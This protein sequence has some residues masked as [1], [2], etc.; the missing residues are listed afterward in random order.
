VIRLL[1]DRGAKVN[2]EGGVVDVPLHTAVHGWDSEWVDIVRLLLSQPG[3]NVNLT[4]NVNISWDEYERAGYYGEP[5]D[6]H[7]Q[8]TPLHCA[9]EL[10]AKLGETF[11]AAQIAN[12]LIAKGRRCS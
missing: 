10:A 4:K 3:I 9:G 5:Y 6:Y 11:V 8:E 2:T 1:L 12:L 7:V